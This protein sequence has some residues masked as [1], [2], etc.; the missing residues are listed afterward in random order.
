MNKF[1]LAA[2]GIASVFAGGTLVA[3][4]MIEVTVPFDFYVGKAAMP[5][6][7]YR[8]APCSAGSTIV[9]VRH[10]TEGIAALHTTLPTGTEPKN[11]GVLVFNK[12][13]EQYFLNEVQGLPGSGNLTLPV[14]K[15]EKSLRAEKAQVRTVEKITVP[16]PAPPQ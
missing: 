5:S 10:C 14:S 2:A 16:E 8:I 4:N 15:L 1:F 3:Q 12:Y 6:G 7:T 13:G 9:V 11:T